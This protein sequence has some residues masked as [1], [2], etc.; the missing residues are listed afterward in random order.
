MK[1]GGHPGG[2]RVGTGRVHS[3]SNENYCR[4]QAESIMIYSVRSDR[5]LQTAGWRTG[6]SQS[7][8]RME[9]STPSRG[10]GFGPQHRGGAGCAFEGS[11]ERSTVYPLRWR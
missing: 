11:T 2:A 6:G 8:S 5:S 4:V 7:G 9:F 3:E 10:Q 1:L